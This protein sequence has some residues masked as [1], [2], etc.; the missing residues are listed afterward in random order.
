MT[1]SP[2]VPG[3]GRA[4]GIAMLVGSSLTLSCMAVLVR[5]T[6]ETQGLGIYAVAFVRFLVCAV[7]V[8]AIARASRIPLRTRSL[9]WLVVR[10]VF[11]AT[12]VTIYY[13]SITHVGL[14]KATILMHT[15]PLWA[16]LFARLFL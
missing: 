14:A 6:K 7:T 2:D 3:R 4:L 11:G 9:K 5:F 16:A 10:G 8:L 15:F 12:A 13:H 1:S